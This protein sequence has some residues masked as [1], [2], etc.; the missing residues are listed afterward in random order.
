[1]MNYYKFIFDGFRKY[2]SSIDSDLVHYEMANSR[3]QAEALF[4]LWASNRGT[5]IVRYRIDDESSKI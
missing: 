5:T 2:S 1:M 4:R 3:E